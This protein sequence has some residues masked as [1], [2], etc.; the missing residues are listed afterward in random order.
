MAL[1]LSKVFAAQR[2][3][4]RNDDE[5]EEEGTQTAACCQN[6]GQNKS[7]RRQS[8]TATSLGHIFLCPC[9]A[10]ARLSSCL[11]NIPR[12]S[13]C[14]PRTA[15]HARP[16]SLYTTT[17][18]Q[19]HTAPH[20]ARTR[21]AT[22][23]F[24]RSGGFASVVPKAPPPFE[25]ET[26]H[27]SFYACACLSTPHTRPHNPPRPRTTTLPPQ[28]GAACRACGAGGRGRASF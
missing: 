17:H 26:S 3:K 12:L 20:N 8:P 28:H 25:N 11:P 13:S 21:P 22:P 16:P 5:K 2:R 10:K 14:C 19:Q 23:A 15:L 24:C 18:T 4:K 6:N 27:A 1:W 7:N 9:S